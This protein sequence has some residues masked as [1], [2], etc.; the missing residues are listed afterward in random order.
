MASSSHSMRYKLKNGV[1]AFVEYGDIFSVPANVLV[2]SSGQSKKK[3]S[4]IAQQMLRNGGEGYRKALDILYKT[5]T[6]LEEGKVYEL[7]RGDLYN[8]DSIYLAVTTAYTEYWFCK[9]WSKRLQELY[10]NILSKADGNRKKSITLPVLGSG[11]AA[12]PIDKCIE[13]AIKSIEKLKPEHL[14]HINIVSNDY[15]TFQKIS[16]ELKSKVP[17]DT[18]TKTSSA[19][20]NYSLK[21]STAYDYLSAATDVSFSGKQNS[22]ADVA[23][24]LN[25]DGGRLRNIEKYSRKTGHK[26]HIGGGNFKGFDDEAG[27]NNFHGN[28]YYISNSRSDNKTWNGNYTSKCLRDAPDSKIV[29]AMENELMS[30]FVDHHGNQRNMSDNNSYYPHHHSPDYHNSNGGDNKYDSSKNRS[31]HGEHRFGQGQLDN[32]A[33]YK[34]DSSK[35]RSKDEERHFGQK[36]FDNGGDNKYDSSKYRSKVEEHG[37]GQG[38]LDNGGDIKYDSSKNRSEGEEHCFGQKQFDNGVDYKYDSSKNRS[39]VQEHRFGQKQFDNSGNYKY[40]SSKNTSKDEEHCV[41]QKQFDNGGDYKYDSSKNTS[42]DEEHCVGPNCTQTCGHV[43]CCVCEGSKD[44]CSFLQ[45]DDVKEDSTSRKQKT[46]NHC[47]DVIKGPDCTLRCGHIVCSKCQASKYS[48]RYS[49]DNG[50]EVDQYLQELSS[51]GNSE[52]SGDEDDHIKEEDDIKTCAICMDVAY[53][54]KCLT[55]CGHVFCTDC[56]ET[57]FKLYK[58]VCPTC[59]TT[60]GILTGDQPTGVMKITKF[61]GGVEGEERAGCYQINYAF[62]SGVQGENHPNPGIRY[63]P[64]S[65]TAYLPATIEGRKIC[66]MLI[67]AFKRK[68]IFTV[69]RSTTTGKENRITWN[70]IHHKT[71][72]NGGPT[73]FGYPDPTYLDRVKEELASKGVTKDDIRDVRLLDDEVIHA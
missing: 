52:N 30:N 3:K 44:P 64:T 26:T 6:I 22:S 19:F 54:P 2:Y 28:D 27:L 21:K 53:N 39:K 14:V 15:D 43:L 57:C 68:L 10:S 50:P 7:P 25:S 5:H 29:H 11:F 40:D 49:R 18:K 51:K 55:K 33:D 1:V 42:K 23:V 58:P 46:C 61:Y 72:M 66:K 41:G 13:V 36:Q 70:D 65:R 67:V 45:D 8:F 34:Y 47:K 35:N 69:G 37:F 32:G 17:N 63:L 59:G 12:A 4:G 62:S 24:S 31:K 73:H 9:S 71:S 16:K 60:Y 56:I 48:C 20:S 38:Q